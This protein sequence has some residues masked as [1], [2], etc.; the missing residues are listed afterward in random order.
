MTFKAARASTMYNRHAF[1]TIFEPLIVRKISTEG[2][3]ALAYYT[4]DSFVEREI[5]N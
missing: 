5:K 3:I 4:M 2:F 1:L